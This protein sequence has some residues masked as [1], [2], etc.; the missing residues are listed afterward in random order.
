M[1]LGKEIIIMTESAKLDLLL[2]K[3]IGLDDKV[4]GLE[5]DMVDMR[6]D[7]KTLHRMDSLILDEIER[8]HKILN[9]HSKDKSKHTV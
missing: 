4:T 2:E 9:K 7:I 5:K 1:S 6:A 3:I 8:V